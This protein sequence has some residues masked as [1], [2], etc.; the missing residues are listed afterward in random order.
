LADYGGFAVFAQGG[1][2][3]LF[4]VLFCIAAGLCKNIH[5]SGSTVIY[6]VLAVFILI[7]L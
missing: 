4:S 5:D 6:I 7:G 1:A 2:I 3:A